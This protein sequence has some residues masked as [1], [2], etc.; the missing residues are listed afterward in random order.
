MRSVAWF[1]FGAVAIVGV[2]WFALRD[3]DAD[4]P[5]ET[6]AYDELERAARAAGAG[7]WATDGCAS[8]PG[9]ELSV[10]IHADA[11]GRD[12]ENLGDESVRPGRPARE[13]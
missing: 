8:N 4:A 11:A 2:T 1:A 12:D 10:E 7:Q 13:L 6:A 5:T 3:G 9:V